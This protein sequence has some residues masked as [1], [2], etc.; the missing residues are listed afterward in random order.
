MWNGVG[1][2]NRSAFSICTSSFS[3]V[4]IF[5]KQSTFVSFFSTAMKSKIMDRNDVA[6]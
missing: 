6:L 5:L 3:I 4:A 2:V 1:V